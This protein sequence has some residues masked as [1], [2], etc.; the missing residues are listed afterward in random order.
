MSIIVV[1]STVCG[2]RT[3][4]AGSLSGK[5][6]V[7]A[8]PAL[9]RASNAFLERRLVSKVVYDTYVPETGRYGGD[10]G[11][12]VAEELFHADSCAALSFLHVL[13]KPS[14]TSDRQM[15][16]LFGVDR[17]LADFELSLEDRADLTRQLQSQF[18]MRY[19]GSEAAARNGRRARAA[20]VRAVRDTLD[21]ILEPHAPL[22]PPFERYAEICARRRESS[23]S[24]IAK[25]RGLEQRGE[26]SKSVREL[27]P[28]FVHM[29]INRVVRVDQAKHEFFIYDLLAQAYSSRC[30]RQRT[31]RANSQVTD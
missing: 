21:R 7:A 3:A 2:P 30:A 14:D 18:A 13:T 17:L 29:H 20:E 8:G 11:L 25:L 12:L 23:R 22:M 6:V 1:L 19:Y 10:A 15:C 28:L 27:V 24:A 26:L 4:L 16:A 9:N 31:I 5:S